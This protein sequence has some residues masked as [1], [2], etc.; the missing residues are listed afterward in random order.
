MFLFSFFHQ[1]FR[2]L[3]SERW[4]IHIDDIGLEGQAVYNCCRNDLVSKDLIPLVKAKICSD[5]Y[6]FKPGTKRYKVEKGLCSLFVKRLVS[7]FI[8]YRKVVFFKAF[9]EPGQFPL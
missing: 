2:A 6:G 1:F 9:L 3:D 8:K 4:A 5:Y 7:A